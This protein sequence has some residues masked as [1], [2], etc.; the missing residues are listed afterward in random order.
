MRNRALA[1]D[2][3]RRADARLD[4]VDA[5]YER[6]SWADVV[7][8][9]Q[10]VVELALKGLLRSVGVDPPRLHDVADVLEAERDRLPEAVLRRL[11]EIAAAS[12]SLRRDRELA[13]Y[14]AEDLTPS[15][16]Y[17][18]ADATEARDAARMVVQIVTGS[19]PESG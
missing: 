6:E 16:F 18:Q 3:I 12:R 10:E 14:G 17:R 19:V 5:L 13:F 11:D 9:S 4:A 2:Y 8:E 7:R 15:D 1:A